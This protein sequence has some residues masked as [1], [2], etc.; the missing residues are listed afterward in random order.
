MEKCPGHADRLARRQ[1][2]VLQVDHRNEVKRVEI[3]KEG[4][5]IERFIPAISGFPLRGLFVFG[6]CLLMQLLTKLAP[7]VTMH[8]GPVFVDAIGEISGGVDVIIGDKEIPA[9]CLSKEHQ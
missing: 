3:G 2:G 6:A 4:S 5:R 1:F 9:E 7:A 8:P